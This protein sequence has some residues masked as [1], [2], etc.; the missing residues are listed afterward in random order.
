MPGQA[1]VEIWGLSTTERLRRA[2]QAAGVP[3]GNIGVGPVDAAMTCP[4][5]LVIFRSDYVF[6]DRLVQGMLAAENTVLMPTDRASGAEGCVAAHVEARLI[7]MALRLLGDGGRNGGGDASAVRFVGPSEVARGYTTRLRRVDTPFL[8]PARPERVHSIE[9]RIFDASYKGVTDLVT[10]WVWPAPARWVTRQLALRGVRPNA[11]TAVSWV[12]VF[13]TALL[14]W[15]GWFGS[16][17]V[18]GWI[19]TFL[20]TVDGKLARVTLTS[21]RFGDVFDHSLDLLHPP[22]WYLAWAAGLPPDAVGR[23][24]ALTWTLWGYVA[25]RAIEGLFIAVCKIDIHTWCR[26]DSRFRAITARRNP[27]MLLLTSAT[28][29]GRPDLGFV[30]VAVWTAISIAFHTVRLAQAFI[31]R[32]RGR[33]VVSWLSGLP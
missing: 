25:G 10:K 22:F 15:R 17:L 8:L 13:V 29:L 16:G 21:S 33:A 1:P 23:D 18:V 30:A 2:A 27:N 26:I 28:V 3:I 11:V 12:L 4:R 7:P 24:W 6:D 14:F 19:M 9:R 32:V 20:D 5:S 31:E